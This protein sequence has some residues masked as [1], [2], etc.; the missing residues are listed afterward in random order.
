V[1]GGAGVSASP[2]SRF[3]LG[4][5]AMRSKDSKDTRT[6][7][8]TSGISTEARWISVLDAGVPLSR[9]SEIS[10]TSCSF[11]VSFLPQALGDSHKASTI[12]IAVI[13][14]RDRKSLSHRSIRVESPIGRETGP[15]GRVDVRMHQLSVNLSV[16]E[17]I[18]FKCVLWRPN[19]ILRHRGNFNFLKRGAE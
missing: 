8:S 10:P 17:K 16:L 6:R 3:L 13:F 1:L 4:L 9:A 14:H 11:R 19:E 12:R 2:R 7:Y 18:V 15:T 5:R